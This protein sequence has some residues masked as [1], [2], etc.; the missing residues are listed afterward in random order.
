MHPWSVVIAVLFA[1]FQIWSDAPA[2][3]VRTKHGRWRMLV[4]MP[5]QPG[6]S[7]TAWGTT[8]SWW[9]PAL[10]ARGARGTDPLT[11]AG[12]RGFD[13]RIRC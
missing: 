6:C 12:L 4:A 1:K 13:G 8:S 5:L 9:P 2:G 11:A 7:G 3:P 10:L